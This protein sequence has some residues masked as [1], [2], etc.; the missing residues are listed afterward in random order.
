MRHDLFEY[1]FSFLTEE[2]KKKFLSVAGERTRHITIVLENLYQTHNASAILRSCDCFGVQDIHIIENSNRYK[3]NKDIDMGSTK[4]LHVHKYSEKENNTVDCINHLKAK[5]YTVY[6]TSPHIKSL[7]LKEVP[8]ENK[9]AFLFGTELTGLTQEAI[10][11]SDGCVHLP[12]YGFTESF[13][14]SVSAALLMAEL[15]NRLRHEKVNF[16]LTNEE[17]IELLYE[18]TMKTVKSAHQIKDRYLVENPED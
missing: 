17:K 14:I 15:A 16:E 5:G 13:N 7:T 10:I 11:A 9:S 2:R 4:W 1:M 12:M 6:A 18:W 8:L 3:I